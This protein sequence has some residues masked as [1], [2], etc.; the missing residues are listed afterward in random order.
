VARFPNSPK[1][2]ANVAYRLALPGAIISTFTQLHFILPSARSVSFDAQIFAMDKAIFGME[3]ALAWDAYVTPQTTEWFSF[4]YYLYFGIL[5]VHVL[6]MSILE[7]RTSVLR[8]FSW[9]I[10]FVFCVGQLVYIAVPGFGPY[11]LLATEFKHP[12]EGP[13]F[14][15]LVAQT[16]SSF[17]GAHRTD[18]FP[19]LHT[20]VPTFFTLFSFRHRRLFPFRY[21]WP[22]LAF[23]TLNIIVATMF[24]RWHYLLDVIAGLTLA[25]TA[26]VTA[27]RLPAWEDARRARSGKP[28]IWLPLFPPPKEEGWVPDEVGFPGLTATRG[29]LGTVTS[30][31]EYHGQRPRGD[32]AAARQSLHDRAPKKAGVSRAAQFRTRPRPGCPDRRSMSMPVCGPKRPWPAASSV[33]GRVSSERRRPRRRPRAASSWLRRVPW[34]GPRFRLCSWARTRRRKTSP[35]ARCHSVGQ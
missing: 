5:L 26:F 13:T 18:I 15:P 19:S 8:E 7:R 27:S 9:G 32:G 2:L 14:W 30:L 11:R 4:F 12:L 23:A 16:V 33:G 21:T 6:P 22:V 3:P 35:W 10:F 24:L 20:A 29:S 31:S 28:P 17:D 1:P 25:T 34:L